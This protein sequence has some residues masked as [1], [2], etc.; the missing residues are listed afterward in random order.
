MNAMYRPDSQPLPPEAAIPCAVPKPQPS[1]CAT[2]SLQIDTPSPQSSSRE[3]LVETPPPYQG[4]HELKPPQQKDLGP[5][6]AVDNTSLADSAY[7]SMASCGSSITARSAAS[8]ITHRTSE[9]RP[10]PGTDLLLFKRGGSEEDLRHY[11]TVRTVVH[12]WLV[13]AIQAQGN[14]SCG[15]FIMRLG[16]IGKSRADAR[17]WVVVFG[18]PELEN[19]VSA[20]FASDSTTTLL[21]SDNAQRLPYIF[22]P[23]CPTL[24]S[25]LLDINVCHRSSSFSNSKTHCG[26]AIFLESPKSP[27]K[28]RQMSTFGGMIKVNFVHGRSELFGMTV[29]HAV[30]KLQLMKDIV[31]STESPSSVEIP[32]GRTTNPLNCA[33][34]ALGRVVDTNSL[35]GVNAGLTKASNDWSL[36]MVNQPRMN[37]VSAP[38]VDNNVG[39]M[40]KADTLQSIHVAERPIFH[41]GASDPVLLLGGMGG[42]RRGELS[43]LPAAIWIEQSAGFVDAYPLELTDNVGK[44]SSNMR[45]KNGP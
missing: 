34:H 13:L 14:E 15:S 22:I 9:G 33:S 16:T 7:V 1:L 10:I 23:K 19:I 31:T 27:G 4:R 43:S 44:G 38:L 20:F 40:A 6:G 39:T 12:E 41:D 18:K 36:F 30:K 2:K 5:G 35:P 45:H 21:R 29:D 42:P 28:G 3:I 8:N 17:Y 11:E 24:P 25:T 37:R 26:T 32:E